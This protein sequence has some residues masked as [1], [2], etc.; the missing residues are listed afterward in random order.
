MA[1]NASFIS[2]QISIVESFLCK[3]LCYRDPQRIRNDVLEMLRNFP[4]LLPRMGSL[5]GSAT[6]N[7][8]LYFAGTIPI[9]YSGAQYNIPISIWIVEDYPFSPPT[10]YVTPT[11]DMIIK[12]KHKHVDSNGLC[13]L[14]YLSSWNPNNCSLLGLASTLSK[15]FSQDPPVRS[16]PQSQ[17][18]LQPKLQQTQ[19]QQPYYPQQKQY[20]QPQPQPQQPYYPQQPPQQQLSQMQQYP[21]TGT[22]QQQYPQSSQQMN[23]PK[24]EFEPPMN[25]LLRK[26]S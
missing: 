24:A 1:S 7:Q 16:Q 3:L 22:S 4:S 20:P 18:Q 2:Q 17:P 15:I 6:S 13:Y 21:L 11:A 10:C 8:I 12:P 26:L 9:F 23:T 25:V 5:G 19:P 14:P